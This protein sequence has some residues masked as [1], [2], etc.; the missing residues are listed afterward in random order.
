M[1]VIQRIRDKA[2]WIIFGAI[3]VSLLAFILQD[4]VSGNGGNMFSGGSTVGKVNGTKIDR[5]E[6]EDKI[7]FYEQANGGQ[8]K[9]DQLVSGVWDV[10]VDN[11]IMTTEYN[12]LGI[13]CNNSELSDLLFGANPPQW[14]TQ[15]FT[16]P[17]T[18]Q[19]DVA[20]ARSRFAEMKKNTSDP[21]IK[22][23]E[24][25]Y[26]KPA[27][28][29]RLRDKY[30]SLISGAVYIPKW[31]AEKA[32][33]D[34]NKI[35]KVS[36]VYVPYSTITDSTLKVSDAEIQAYIQKHP[37]GFKKDEE[38][39]S[40]QYV[41]FSLSPSG[42]DSLRARNDMNLLKEEFVAATDV[43][44]FLSV[45][46]SDMPYYNSY[47]SRN[48]IK[49]AVNDSLF[50]RG[51]GSFYG[52]YLDGSNYIVAKIVGVRSIPDSAKVRHILVSTH[53]QDQQGGSGLYRMRDDSAAYK[54]LDT[55][56][57]ELRSGKN[58]DSVCIKYS[59]DP[60][61]SNK[62]GVYDFFPSGRMDAAF[63]D[64]CFTGTTGQSKIVKTAY[65]YHYIEILGQKGSSSGYNIAYLSK[66]ILVGT[67]TE[68]K[69][70]TASAKFAGDS[71][72]FASFETNAKKENLLPTPVTD[73]KKSDFSIPGTQDTR[74]IVRW[75]FENKTGSISEP[76]NVGDKIIVA[77]ITGASDKGLMSVSTARPM[78]EYLVMNEKKA[79]QIIR[80]K[81]KGSTLEEIAKNA[82][83]MVQLADSVSY[84]GYIFGTVGN[85]I[86]IIGAA[87]NKNIKGKVSSPIAGNTGVFVLR[88]EST[89][90]TANASSGNAEMMREQQEG[91]MRQ[92]AGYRSLEALKKSAVVDDYRLKFY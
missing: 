42:A 58:F 77:C 35:A 21:Q 60:G 46:N 16:N 37:G 47:V 75:A 92:Q 25:G 8:T 87:F 1:S 27:I 50:S 69:A 40:L 45:K 74:N 15:A 72:D 83:S 76:F 28:D 36:Y 41:S 61:S 30:S 51:S 22:N 66:P 82:G 54:R 89:G 29:Q 34:N 26:I 78:V 79:E 63:N 86:K 65:G 23:I 71:K 91:M 5:I 44:T 18:G 81:F 31:L 52:P 9:R 11:I 39:R 85:E 6:F 53:Q 13:S 33:A 62:G 56:L 17:Q 57:A 20:T 2:A 3:G 48:E 59:E 67:E 32:N 10:M 4:A 24:D 84:G 55:A 38:T 19:F 14:M 43:S 49:Q 73:L 12:K 68:D 64:F 80:T 88:G 7:N 70:A 90:A